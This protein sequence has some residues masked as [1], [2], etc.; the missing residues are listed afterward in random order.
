MQCPWALHSAY[1]DD[2][3]ASL[4]LILFIIIV[5]SRLFIRIFSL[6]LFEFLLVSF[7]LIVVHVHGH[8]GHYCPMLLVG[9]HATFCVIFSWGTRLRNT[10]HPQRR[11]G[12]RTKRGKKGSARPSR[13]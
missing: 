9:T 3:N 8:S 7:D 5:F 12:I 13:R 11:G 4:L 1:R 2:G 10:L 6:F